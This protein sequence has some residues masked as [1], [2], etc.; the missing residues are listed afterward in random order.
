MQK[1]KAISY[2]IL[3]SIYKSFCEGATSEYLSLCY[4]KQANYRDSTINYICNHDEKLEYSKSFNN[5][6][7]FIEKYCGLNHLNIEG[8]LKLRDYQV[9]ILEGLL[10]N[11]FTIING[12]RQSGVSLINKC[13]MVYNIVFKQNRTYGILTEKHQVSRKFFKD[14]LGIYSTLPFHMQPGIIRKTNS[15][16]EFENGVIITSMPIHN[17]K[18][19]SS[20]K[21]KIINGTLIPHE[22]IGLDYGF[23]SNKNS[24]LLDNIIPKIIKESSSKIILSTTGSSKNS[25]INKLYN[26]AS[27]EETDPFKNKIFKAY[28]IPWYI[29][30][31]RNLEWYNKQILMYGKD[32]FDREYNNI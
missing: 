14:V 9:E 23:F 29:V 18:Y 27:R 30:P 13:Y 20:N 31:G 24:Y 4:R 5:I 26:N 25:Y 11:R 28:N 16:V 15:Y 8:N 6:S 21:Y 10:N 2:N 22:I 7:Y 3:Q 17:S 32:I 1:I 12:S 19:I